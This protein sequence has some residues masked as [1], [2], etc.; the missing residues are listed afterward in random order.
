M[1]RVFTFIALF[2]LTLSTNA[3]T[4]SVSYT[5]S[6]ENFSNPERG[7]YHHKETN[8]TSYSPL[9]QTTLANYRN[10]EKI[11]LIMR[12]FYLNDFVNRL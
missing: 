9:T 6:T 7:F 11:T 2:L 10:N 4:T 5:E 8:S 3:Q 12:L 1:K